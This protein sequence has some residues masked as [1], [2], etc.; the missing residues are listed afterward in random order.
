MSA[1]NVSI[2]MCQLNLTTGDFEG[3]VTLA[4]DALSNNKADVYLFQE[5]M[6][7][8]YVADDMMLDEGFILGAAAAVD[9][10][11]ALSK[12]FDT[13]IVF[14]AP[15]KG[16]KNSKRTANMAI[17]ADRGQI[18]WQHA[19]YKLVNYDVFDDKRY[20]EKGAV[21]ASTEVYLWQRDGK[22]LRVAIRIC[23]DIWVDD[24]HIDADVVW[25]INSSPFAIGK[26]KRRRDIVLAFSKNSGAPVFYVNQVGGNDELVFDGGSCAVDSVGGFYEMKQ[27]KA[28]VDVVE[29]GPEVHDGQTVWALKT[30]QPVPDYT[31]DQLRARGFA[32]KYVAACLGLR[33]YFNKVGVWK[34]VVLGLSGGADSALVA[35][36]AADAL[37]AEKVRAITMPS[38]YTSDLSNT[39]AFRLAAGVGT[40]IKT[41]TLPIKD[42]FE[43]YRSVFDAGLG[44]LDEGLAHENL[45]AQIRGDHLSFYSNAYGAAILSTGN[46]SEI[47]MGYCTLYGDMR[48]AINPIG[49][50]YKT[51]VFKLIEFRA[52]QYWEEDAIF[53]DMFF[54][55][56]GVKLQPMTFD[57]SQALTE[58][59]ER[60]PSAELREGQL[61]TDSLPDYWTLDPI[62]QAMID[63]KESWTNERVAQ[64]TN[65]PI[66]LVNRVR[67]ML[68]RSEYKRWQSAPKVKIH[69]KS[70]TKKDWRYPM[71]NKFIG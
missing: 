25:A 42:I 11:V 56:F 36:I 32:E 40:G 55:A 31:L 64:E 23:E 54:D 35:M 71:V 3:N 6:V 29:I 41:Y 30:L 66:Q 65:A 70:F 61:D 21:P 16:R 47:S 5:C 38:A 50:L 15:Y 33:D 37:G 1:S 28:G 43:A 46:K 18:V 7:S 59:G 44:E 63:N 24:R 53:S 17:V 34:S 9:Q 10:M 57:A 49:D 27:W 14:G 52:A 69:M 13:T 26:A 60:P 4:R 2:A 62:L 20:Y 12:E 8:N 68:R 67:A 22:S 48:G 19:K 39:L 51:E 45:Q 58:T